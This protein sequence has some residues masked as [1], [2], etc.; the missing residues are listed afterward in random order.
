MSQIPER[1][2]REPL[3]SAPPAKTILLAEDEDQLRRFV[4]KALEARGYTTILARDGREAMAL[5]NSL[6]GPIDLLLSDIDMPGM[7]GIALAETLGMARPGTRVLLMSGL[8]SPVTSRQ[9]GWGF[10][11]KPFRFDVLM[12]K[13]AAALEADP[14]APGF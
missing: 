3:G 14:S 10:L 6:D 12:S 5:A 8:Q 4:A 7:D 13:V 1:I 11:G 9:H 2:S